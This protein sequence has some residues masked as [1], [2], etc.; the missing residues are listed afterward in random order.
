MD[1]GVKWIDMSLYCKLGANIMEM[2]IIHLELSFPHVAEYN[3]VEWTNKQ[4]C[5]PPDWPKRA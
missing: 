3:L 1:L 4:G 5:K 2:T